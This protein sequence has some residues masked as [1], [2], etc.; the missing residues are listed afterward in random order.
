M[1][2]KGKILSVISF[3]CLAVALFMVGVWAVT[4]T[5]FKVSGNI[6]YIVPAP[7]ES[8]YPYLTFSYSDETSGASL[9]STRSATPLTASVV[10][11]STDASVVT[12]AVVPEQIRHNGKNYTVTTISGGRTYST[13]AFANCTNLTSIEIPSSIISIGG[14]AF[15][16]CSGLTSI[17]IPTSVISIG[18]DAFYKCTG[19]TNIEI[20]SSVT[21]IGSYAFYGCTSLSSIAIPTSVTCI[22][23]STFRNC[24]GLKSVIM[25]SSVTSIGNYAFYG[26]SGLTCGLIMP[27]SVTSIGNNAFYNCT[28]LTSVT[29]GSGVT[30]IGE[31]AFS[32]CSGLTGE[33]IIPNGVTSIGKS[34]FYKCSGLTSMNY[35]GTLKDW[36]SI[37]F[38]DDYSNPTYYTKSL[39]INGKTITSITAEDLEGV[40]SIGQYAFRY[41]IGLTS[42]EIPNSVTSIGNYA[43]YDCSGL[44]GMNY[45]GTLKEWVSVSFG[46]FSSTPTC[47][48][49][50]LVIN[51]EAITTITADDLSGVAGIGAYAFYNCAGLA[52]IAI[53]TSVTSIGNVAFYGC[54]GL[55][56]IEIPNSVT[57]IGNYV[58]R[59]CTGLTS[60]AIP[61]SV[62]S[63]GIRAFEEC[64][65][66]TNIEIPSSVT[67]IGESAF[68]DCTGLT[69]IVVDENNNVYDS[70]DNCN[71]IIE[72]ETDTLI[73]S[74]KNTT[75]PYSVK[76]IGDSAF[77]GRGGLTGELIIPNS[78]TSI[79]DYAFSSC[80]GPTGVTIPSSV[81]S[82]GWDAFSNCRNL[83][84]VTIGS[85]VTSIGGYAFS[86]CSKLTTI[87]IDSETVASGLTGKSATIMGYILYK[88][89]TIYIKEGLTVT[90]YISTNYTLGTSDKDGYVMYTA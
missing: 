38:G 90:E 12:E 68:H 2:I 18:S 11:C 80:S 41:C 8:E 37:T 40:T 45:L 71:A 9:M 43:F 39:V 32:G 29:I 78:V 76:S 33:L 17:A 88:A 62:I 54:S 52:S 59:G 69:S 3:M 15:Y 25:G 34:A 73:Q 30:S 84:S 63:I 20:P 13:G 44:T 58:F 28:S 7:D 53:P 81:T 4:E 56:S 31:S 72:T 35:L 23:G 14:Y 75:I 5:D 36:V 86:S 51:G 1:S 27:N 74:C 50:S 82:I 6:E 87:T 85:G 48:T 47:Y 70:R 42:I 10:D 16:K 61:T 67:N 26:C 89:T 79:G 66:L 65:G 19:L 46:G 49:K 22:E 24:S 83:T 64:T 57:S 55:K 21:S 77:M 60:I